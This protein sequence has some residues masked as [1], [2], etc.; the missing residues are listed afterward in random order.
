MSILEHKHGDLYARRV[1]ADY[2]NDSFAFV[3]HLFYR[4]ALYQR[5]LHTVSLYT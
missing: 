1:A 2:V 4:V 5:V 3:L